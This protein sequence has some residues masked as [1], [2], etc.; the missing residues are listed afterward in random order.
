MVRDEGRER[1]NGKIVRKRERGGNGER[2]IG[3]M[4]RG[5]GQ[6]RH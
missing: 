6:H 3:K 1:E 2:E 5:I 4:E